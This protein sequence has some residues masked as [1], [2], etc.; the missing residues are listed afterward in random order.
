[1][2]KYD[3]RAAV[4]MI[5]SLVIMGVVGIVPLLAA[6]NYSF[7]DLFTIREAYWVGDQWYRQII[8]S[9]RFYE[10][11]GRSVLFSIL[12]LT[13]QVS[14]G[15]A[16]A[17]MVARMGPARIFVLMLVALPLVVPWN[18]IAMM[19][20]SLIDLK[21]GIL[22]KLFTF[23]GMVIDYKFNP[24]H[25]W[26]LLIVIDTW[27]WLGLVTI[28]AYAGFTGIPEAYYRAAAIDGASDIAVFRYIE[29]PKIINALSIAILLRFVDSFMINTEAFA[30][31]AG[32]P[33]NATT[34]LSLDLS[35]DIKGFNYGPAA[36]R[37]MLSFLIVITVAWLFRIWVDRR[38][39][40]D[41]DIFT[42]TEK[43]K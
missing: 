35:E 36:A 5:P 27:H 21:S 11:F 29:F 15:V 3:N 19:W 17:R 40:G 8:T 2:K 13:V 42:G 9:S 25:T 16:L 37:S 24:I 22:G 33:Q 23:S 1:M 6:F 31:N 20:Q 32:G 34:F 10:S 26:I 18:M 4:L 39:D 43:I 30:I 12:A 38:S 14:L 28:L 7:F 41:G